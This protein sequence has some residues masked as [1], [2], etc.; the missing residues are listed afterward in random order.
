MLW[1]FCQT[2]NDAQDGKS[3]V[4]KC[5]VRNGVWGWSDQEQL[6][7]LERGGV[8][9][10]HQLY[11][12]TLPATHAK[13]PGRI[14]PERL[15]QRADLLKHTSRKGDT[16]CVATFLAL[17][18]SEADL[19]S[20][21]GLASARGSTVTAL[22]SGVSI[23]PNGR[24]EDLARV[25]A[26][27]TR[28][29]GAARTKPGR[30][31]GNQVAAEKARARTLVKLRPARALWRSRKAS[32]LTVAQISEQVGLSGKTLYRELGRR[33]AVERKRK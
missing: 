30:R 31:M 15:T 14:R 25:V 5:Y 26:D 17:G 23:R 21:L 4:A 20:A 11:Q 29:R 2:E 13:H 3:S 8:L 7:L 24:A 22:D 16:I 10:R 1:K 18:V 19:I 32:R 33:P 12:D 28:A 9:D 27:W 6:E